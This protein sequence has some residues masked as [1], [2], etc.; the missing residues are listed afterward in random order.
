MTHHHP[1]PAEIGVDALRAALDRSDGVPRT[2]VDVRE[3][4]EFAA[5]HVPGALHVP[6]S[7]FVDRVHEVV[8]LPGKVYLIC[9]VGG[10]SGQVAAWLAQQ[11]HATVNVAGGTSA[12]R[13]AGYPVE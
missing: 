9:E 13:R 12:W 4:H 3:D 6:M 11:G 5:G 7:G 2:V 8:G 1:E 10:R